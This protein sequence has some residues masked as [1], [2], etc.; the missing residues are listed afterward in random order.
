MQRES[1]IWRP[2]GRKKDG[3]REVV[4]WQS[5][6]NSQSEHN[7]HWAPERCFLLDEYEEDAVLAQSV[8]CYYR[9]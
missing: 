6:G 4:A 1:L 8:K 3:E 2:M 7:S 9:E 5:A